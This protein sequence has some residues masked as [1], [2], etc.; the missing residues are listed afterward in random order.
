MAK[1]IFTVLSFV[2]S[3]AAAPTVGEAQICHVIYSHMEVVEAR[4]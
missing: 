3:L 4:L 2:H 1:M